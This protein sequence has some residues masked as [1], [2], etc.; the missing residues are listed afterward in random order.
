ML[1]AVWLGS[2]SSHSSFAQS[3]KFEKLCSNQVE[4][5]LETVTFN[6]NK[7]RVK[8][9]YTDSTRKILQSNTYRATLYSASNADSFWNERMKAFANGVQSKID[10]SAAT[11]YE[12]IIIDEAADDLNEFWKIKDSNHKTIAVLVTI[13]EMTYYV[14]PTNSFEVN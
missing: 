9:T 5:Y 13:E 11:S 12:K 2:L 7:K 14:C 6:A 4:P 8:I 10:L 3:M 1:L